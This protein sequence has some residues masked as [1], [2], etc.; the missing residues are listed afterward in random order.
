MLTCRSV[1]A[2]LVD[3]GDGGSLLPSRP[4]PLSTH[5]VAGEGQLWAGRRK[6]RPVRTVGGGQEA[7]TS[8]EEVVPGWARQVVSRVSVR[9]AV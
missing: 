7:L 6:P 1:A 2:R 9:R 3:G 4:V 8:P 5:G